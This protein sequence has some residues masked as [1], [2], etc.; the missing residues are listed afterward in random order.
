MQS[1]DLKAYLK[2]SKHLIFF[3]S[4]L[5]TILREKLS[6]SIKTNGY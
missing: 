6:K 1:Y 4:L 3:T 2:I 5:G